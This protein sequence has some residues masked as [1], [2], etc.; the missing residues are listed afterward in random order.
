MLSFLVRND[1]WVVMELMEGGTLT[2]VIDN[3][4]NEFNEPQIATVIYE[5]FILIDFERTGCVA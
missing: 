2:D 4:V 1:L 5:V 3:N